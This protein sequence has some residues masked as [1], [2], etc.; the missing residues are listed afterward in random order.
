MLIGKAL[1]NEEQKLKQKICCSHHL[2]I[3]RYTEAEGS[4][5]TIMKLAIGR[6]L[7]IFPNRKA[8]SR[9]EE[10]LTSNQL[11]FKADDDLGNLIQLQTEIGH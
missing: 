4:S 7:C 9:V 8:L 2:N 6:L 5:P 3:A 1:D 11:V 10:M